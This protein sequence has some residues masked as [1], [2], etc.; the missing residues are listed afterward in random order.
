MPIQDPLIHPA[1]LDPRQ[2]AE[3]NLYELAPAVGRK[4]I[5]GP[6]RHAPDRQFDLEHL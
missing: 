5:A 3:V 6:E 4:P 1:S 2:W